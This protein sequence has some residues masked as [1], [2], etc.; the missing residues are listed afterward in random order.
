[1]VSPEGAMMRGLRFV[2]L[3][4]VLVASVVAVSQGMKGGYVWGALA[5]VGLAGTLFA[6]RVANNDNALRLYSIAFCVAL[7]ALAVVF[8]VLAATSAPDR[9][10]AFIGLAVL[11]LA[12][13]G[14]AVALT[15]AVERRRRQSPERVRSDAGTSGSE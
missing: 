6:K 14:G 2:V 8:A 15:V 4:L 7:V 10:G 13:A 1:M 3:G 9:R 5:L 12:M 11:W